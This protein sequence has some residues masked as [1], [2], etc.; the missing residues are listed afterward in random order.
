MTNHSISLAYR[1]NQRQRR[2]SVFVT[3]T[4]AASSVALASRASFAEAAFSPPLPFVSRPSS[5]FARRDF[6]SSTARTSNRGGSADCVDLARVH[7]QFHDA[8]ESASLRASSDDVLLW[9]QYGQ[10]SNAR[11][12]LSSLA[13]KYGGLY[14]GVNEESKN[15][16]QS[17]HESSPDGILGFQVDDLQE[18]Y[19]DINTQFTMQDFEQFQDY[20]SQ[21]EKEV[22]IPV[23]RALNSR[24][25]S[26]TKRRVA[27]SLLRSGQSRAMF[28]LD[29]R[30]KSG[31]YKSNQSDLAEEKEVPPWFPWLPSKSQIM[32]LKVKQLQAACKER[33][34]IQNGKKAD[35]Q[36]RLLMW[37]TV[38]DRKRISDRLTGLRDLID[39]AKQKAKESDE[40]YD[41]G[42]LTSRRVAMTNESTKDK[43]SKRGILGLVDQSFFDTDKPVDLSPCEEDD[44]DEADSSIVDEESISQ[45]SR[46]FNAPST[47]S[48]RDVREMYMEA[49]FADQNGDRVKSKR[50]LRQLRDVTPHDM[51]VVRRLARMEQEDGN[52]ATARML[53]Q[54]GLRQD[55]SN[56]YLLHGLGQLEREA[57]NDSLAKKYF[58]ISIEKNPSFSNPYHALG[59]LEH[60]HGNIKSA[61]AV[62]KMGLKYNPTNHRLHHALGD[63][64]LDAQMLDL[65][66]DSYLASLQNVEREWGKS[67]AYTSLSF[68]AYAKGDIEECRALLRQSL[69]INGGM[70]A[71]GVIALA[72]LEESEGNINDA[73]K[74]Y[75]DSISNYERKRL[76]RIS[77]HRESSQLE[78]EVDPFDSS[79][80]VTRLENQHSGSYAG[81]K[82]INVFRSWARMEEIHGNYETAHIV[83]SRAVRLFP[84]STVL[85]TEWAKLQED[86]NRA[87]KA[88]LLFEAASAE[89][90][91]L[92]AEFE[93]KRTNFQDAQSILFRGAQSVA[94]SSESSVDCK[95]RLASLFHTWGVCEYHLGNDA[96]AEQLFDDA[97][98]VT[99]SG[100]ADSNIRSLIL[101]SM[102]RLEFSRQ[103]YLLAQHC[104]A[105]SL[106][107]NLLP[108]GN[109]LLWKLWAD[110]AEMMENDHLV[111]R[112]R[113]QA[114]LMYQEESG[115]TASDLSR[116]LEERDIKSNSSGGRT[117]PV[118]KEMFRRTPWYIKVCIPGRMDKSWHDG[119]RLWEL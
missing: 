11:K 34:L 60:S 104:V 55:P 36:R 115:G 44:D 67:F 89:P 38:Q 30:T 59:T 9:D 101:Y 84:E 62:I 94:E 40:S 107:E 37:A 51:R 53:L 105:L 93:M 18:Q 25:S 26:P 112:C 49:K 1:S 28:A 6:S 73:R 69:D 23:V 98:R 50:I 97:I 78:R 118:M 14:T 17:D 2:R 8:F 41:V 29:K 4:I 92:F 96:R 117:G 88:K 108:G 91:R 7:R 111:Q 68:V 65:A 39:S 116:I 15:S 3:T 61:L 10:L 72:Q 77:V 46:S 71:Q 21:L 85:L 57:G 76:R 82:W 74:V 31:S 113:E 109:S 54:K 16:S 110:I 66:E 32:C 56:S 80:L 87:D 81:D 58:R 35:L 20:S 63:I 27:A 103:E 79:F 70:H 90:Y 43:R 47:F 13:G 19:Y 119:A 45:L 48:N 106:K 22:K 12:Q 42:S 75:R 102:A 52:L 83:F 33:G 24:M 5:P 64:Y 95:I 114:A 99:G 86:H 100:E